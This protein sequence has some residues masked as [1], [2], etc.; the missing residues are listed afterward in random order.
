[1]FVYRDENFGKMTK[2]KN[3]F[4]PYGQ[5]QQGVVVAAMNLKQVQSIIVLWMLIQIVD[6]Q[7][8]P[9]PMTCEE[10]EPL[11]PFC[12]PCCWCVPDEGSDFTCP[13][14]GNRKSSIEYVQDTSLIEDLL[15]YE[16]DDTNV[17]PTLTPLGC[18]PYRTVACALGGGG[19]EC[20]TGITE[21]LYPICDMP[22]TESND[23]KICAFEFVTSSNKKKNPKC[24]ESYSLRTLMTNNNI[25]GDKNVITIPTH[26]GQCGVCSSAQDL[27]TNLK[28]EL[29][30][31]ALLC[32][33]IISNFLQLEP[34]PA[35]V[36]LAMDLTTQCFEDIGFTSDC[37]Y[38]WASN[39]ANSA[40]AGCAQFC[41][42][43]LMPCIPPP[44]ETQPSD[45][46]ECQRRAGEQLYDPPNSCNLNQCLQCDLMRT[47]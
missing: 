39:A 9:L 29:N 2:T 6:A 36:T 16:L 26:K 37:A 19:A 1:M 47:N 10:A 27:A 25:K 24:G 21:P 45:P 33:L 20:F 15:S 28:P 7:P 17:P 13:D 42:P 30:V 31:A 34:T 46:E 43:Y 35:E 41:V 23:E 40:I 12:E 8:P 4:R 11:L 22:D 5:H 14:I 44:G 38:L 32:G 3:S 18:Q